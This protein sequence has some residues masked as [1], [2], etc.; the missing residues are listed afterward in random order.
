MGAAGWRL[1]IHDSL[2]STQTLAIELAEQGE[3]GGLAIL[4]RRQTQGRGR[5]GRSWQSQAGNLHLSVLLRPSGPAREIAGQALL[6]AV[7]LHEAALHHAPGR[8]L[9]LKWPNDLMEEG[10]K[11]AGILA[12]ASL[13]PAGNIVHLVL[14]F[15]V[16]LAHAPAVEGRATA[17]LGPIPPEDFARTLVDRLAHWQEIRAGQGFAPI[18]AAWEERGPPRGTVLTL[19]QGDNP[20]TGRYEGLAGDGGLRLATADGPLVFHAGEVIGDGHASRG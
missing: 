8:P 12:E 9:R 14:G 15:G 13:D 4:A 18:R 5:E 20:T 3:A 17:C 2:P 10:A 1:R 6:A 19:R 7:A 11:L 16:N